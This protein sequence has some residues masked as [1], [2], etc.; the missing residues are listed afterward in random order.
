MKMKG[1]RRAG[2]VGLLLIF[3]CLSASEVPIEGYLA[4]ADDTRLFYRVMGTGPDTVVVVHGGPGAGMN[5]VLPDLGPLA[6]KRTV[7]YFDQ[8][9]GDRSELPV[10]TFL[11]GNWPVQSKTV[12]E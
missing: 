1:F 4:G 11:S 10:D 12:S 3:G 6:R 8:R 2:F 9:G 5:A 7:V